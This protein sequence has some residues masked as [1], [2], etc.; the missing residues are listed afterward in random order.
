MQPGN[1]FLAAQF[2]DLNFSH[3][4]ISFDALVK[5]KQPVRNG[6]HRIVA[7]LALYIFADKKSGGLTTRKVKR[8]ALNETLKF[9]FAIQASK[10]LAYHRAEG[11]DED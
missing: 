10:R 8:E 4:R 5:P 11:I 3:D 2:H 1:G 7:Q 6:E 9:R